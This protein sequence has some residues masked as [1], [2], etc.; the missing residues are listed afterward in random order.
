MRQPD[1]TMIRQHSS[2]SSWSK[3]S[4][5]LDGVSSD[6]L[7][8]VRQNLAEEAHRGLHQVESS[9][10]DQDFLPPNVEPGF[11]DR[12]LTGDETSKPAPSQRCDKSS[13]SNEPWALFL[14]PQQVQALPGGLSERDCRLRQRPLHP[15]EVHG[16]SPRQG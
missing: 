14:L 9:G 5:S 6:E 13:A 12:Y 4:S 7:E 15:H 3:T 11:E 1:G 16:G 10:K 8:R 2:W